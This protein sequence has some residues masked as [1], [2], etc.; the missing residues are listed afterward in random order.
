MAQAE[1]MAEWNWIAPYRAKQRVWGPAELL[2]E[3][4]RAEARSWRPHGAAALVVAERYLRRLRVGLANG[5]VDSWRLGPAP[6]APLLRA[7]RNLRVQAWVLAHGL[8]PLMGVAWS[9]WAV[10]RWLAS[11][12]PAELVKWVLTL[13]RD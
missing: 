11:W 6:D 5:R 8:G 12:L 13:A 2:A 4:E 7:E 10:G 9:A 1:L 3:L